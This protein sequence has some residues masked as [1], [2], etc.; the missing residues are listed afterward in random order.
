YEEDPSGVHAGLVAIKTKKETEYRAYEACKRQIDSLTKG[1]LKVHRDKAIKVIQTLFLYHI[2]KTRQQGITA[3]EISNSILIEREEDSNPD[4]NIQHYETIAENLKKELRQIVQTFDDEGRARYRFDPVFTGVDPRD[5]FKKARDEAE[6]N[7]LMQKE[8]WDHL[9]ALDEWPVKTRQMT[10]DISGGVKS[11]FRDI[12]PFIAPWGDR[13]L[14]ESKDQ[15]L[16]I[17]WNGRQIFGLVSMRDLGRVVSENVP[18]PPINSDET[19]RDFAVFIGSRP[20]SKEVVNKLLSQRK[21]PRILFWTPG[22]MTQEEKDRLLDF[23]A[24]KKLVSDW[25]GKESEDAV[26]VISWVAESLKTGLGKIQKI[27]DN[28]FARGRID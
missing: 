16:E 11:M 2:A 19:D 1:Y 27:V 28:S 18:L 14:K 12:A 8:A 26:A 13:T 9:L 17:N 21:D 25:Q 10:I 22:H 15:S 3:E 20:I 7:E 4:E 5:E 24:Y 23:A 6:S